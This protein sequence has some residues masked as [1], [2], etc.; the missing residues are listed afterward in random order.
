MEA[1]LQAQIL[2]SKYYLARQCAGV[3]RDIYYAM[4]F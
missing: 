2:L 3:D 4:D 1:L